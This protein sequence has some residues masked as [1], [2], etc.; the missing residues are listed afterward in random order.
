MNICN[1]AIVCTMDRM[2]TLKIRV[3]SLALFAM[4]CA[5][6][7]CLIV[8]LTAHSA[9]LPV[10][11]V[12]APDSAD[13]AAAL[14]GGQPTH[15]ANQDVHVFGILARQRGAAAIV[16]ISGDSPRTVSLGAP[17]MQGATLADVRPRSIVIDRNGA[18]SEVFL[19][20]DEGTPTV[21]VR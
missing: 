1:F 21:Y 17:L 2:N 8:T 7:T 6:L 20:A 18:R 9:P 14:F 19:P 13:E 12:R 16:S 3:L 11:T 5:T 4:L 10:A 15:N